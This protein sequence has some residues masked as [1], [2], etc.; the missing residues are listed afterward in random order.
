MYLISLTSTYCYTNVEETPAILSSIMFVDNHFGGSYYP[1]GSTLNLIGKLEKVIEENNGHMIY[2]TEVEEIIVEDNRAIK[3]KLDNETNISAKYI[4]NSGTVWNLYNKLLKENVSED[5]KN[6]VNS[7]EPSYPSV[8]LF[9]LV[10]EEAI[11]KGTLPIEMLIGDKTKLDEDEITVYILSIDDKTL[12]KKGYHTI[13]AIGPTFKEWPKGFKNNYNTEKYREMKEVEKN[14]VLDVLEKRFP[15]FKENLCYVEISTPTTLNRYVLKEK[16]SVAG[17]KQKLGQHMMKRLKSKSEV[18]SLFNCGESTV[19]GTGTPAVTISGISAAN[20]ILRELGM[21]EFEYKENMKNYVN[22][23]KKPFE[24]NQ[25]KIGKN[26]EEDKLAKLALKCQFCEKPSCEKSC[27]YNMPIR[28]INRRV[29]VGNFYGAK[30]LLK[31]YD[32]NPCLNCESKECENHCVRKGF[33]KEVSI[34]EINSK[35]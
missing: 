2:N 14:R 5:I 18:D 26:E 24:Y 32:I 19:M 8:V 35:L 25:I 4:V 23:V 29:A 31:D 16:G 33:A 20:L 13:M 22:I 30:N 17:P 12:C 28:D 27:K 15:G 11:P 10:K 1:A 7:L 6:W 34:R 3:V 21:E 9:A